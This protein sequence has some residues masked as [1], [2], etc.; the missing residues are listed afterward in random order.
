MTYVLNLDQYTFNPDIK[1]HNES[2][3][4][5]LL[6]PL[7]RTTEE[8]MDK[9]L[10]IYELLMLNEDGWN[11]LNRLIIPNKIKWVIDKWT[12]LKSRCMGE[13]DSEKNF[14]RPSNI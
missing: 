4:D 5:P 3:L 12:K 13:N 6:H 2:G 8:G 11:N 9:I 7:I 14:T 10:Y 1:A